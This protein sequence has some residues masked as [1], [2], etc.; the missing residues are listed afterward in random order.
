VSGL[1]ASMSRPGPVWRRHLDLLLD[2]LRPPR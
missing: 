2:G 1:C